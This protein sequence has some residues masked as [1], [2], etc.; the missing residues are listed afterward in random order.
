MGWLSASVITWGR[1][2]Y[3]M[4]LARVMTLS[5]SALELLPTNSASAQLLAISRT[6]SASAW[7]ESRPDPEDRADRRDL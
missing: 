2:N 1:T 4:S 6:P 7:P 5:Q 3:A